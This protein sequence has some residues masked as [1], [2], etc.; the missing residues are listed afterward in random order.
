MENILLGLVGSSPA[1]VAVLITVWQF[2]KYLKEERIEWRAA[3]VTALNNNS[4]A[5]AAQTSAMNAQAE[6][7]K[8]LVV[9]IEKHD[10]MARAFF[11]SM[12]KK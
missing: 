2:L 11:S 3:I 8:A 12:E 4:T 5:I 10:E 9:A 1:A 6:T 7:M